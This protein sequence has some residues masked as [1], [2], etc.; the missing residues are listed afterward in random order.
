MGRV[1]TNEKLNEKIL[2]D[3]KAEIKW[4]EIRE[5]HGV[6]NPYINSVQG[7]Y[8]A[9]INRVKMEK[10]GKEVYFEGSRIHDGKPA[11]ITKFNIND[12]SD[13]ELDRM[14]LGRFK[15]NA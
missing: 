2:V 5:K 12:L 9:E 15:K 3:L 7:I 4:K 6:D 11:P 13:E 1:A 8:Q 10:T 14:G